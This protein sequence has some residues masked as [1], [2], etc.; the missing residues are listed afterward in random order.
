MI[1]SSQRSASGTG[2]GSLGETPGDDTRLKVAVGIDDIEVKACARPEVS[3]EASHRCSV[4]APGRLQS[5]NTSWKP[6]ARQRSKP[7]ACGSAEASL[8]L[9]GIVSVHS[10]R[11]HETIVSLI[12]EPAIATGHSLSRSQNGH[13]LGARCSQVSRTVPPGTM[14]YSMRV[15][16]G[17]PHMKR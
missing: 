11:K 3:P 5:D 2:S 17:V 14:L 4:G 7:R 8:E 15:G 16:K 9:E 1:G 10:Q 13:Q 12:L 6:S